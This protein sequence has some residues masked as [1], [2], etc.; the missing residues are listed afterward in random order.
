M[1][2]KL[3]NNLYFS[4]YRDDRQAYLNLQTDCKE[5]KTKIDSLDGKCCIEMIKRFGEGVSMHDIDS[6]AVN[7]T[8]EEMKELSKSKEQSL[9]DGMNKKLVSLKN[10]NFWGLHPHY[11]RPLGMGRFRSY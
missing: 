4:I 2:E 10:S 7:R 1:Q 9:Y 8:L 11:V 5:L 3:E 6:F